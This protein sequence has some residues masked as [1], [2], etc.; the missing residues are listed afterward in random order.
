MK[1]SI[2]LWQLAGFAVTSLGGTILHFL[3]EWLGK[4]IWIA[5]FS[6]VNESTWEHMKLLFWPML[7][8]A[9]VQS[10]FFGDRKD[11]WCIKLRGVFLGLACIPV[12]FY[13]Y[14]G[15]IGKSPDWLNISIFFVAAAIAY[16]YEARLFLANKQTCRSPKLAIAALVLIA[17]C[18]A[19]FTFI[20][21]KLG[22]FMDPTSQSFGITFNRLGTLIAEATFDY[23]AAL[24]L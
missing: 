6:G 3:Y 11:F 5:P 2:G 9:I 19:V 8:F 10:F 7:V 15:V 1:K 16:I 14:N 21:P 24:K 17:L 23:S 4:S 22:I 13:T 20:P 12:L 18:F